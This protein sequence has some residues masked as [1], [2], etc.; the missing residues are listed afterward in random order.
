M[1]VRAA[2]GTAAVGRRGRHTPGWARSSA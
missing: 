1:S 2:P